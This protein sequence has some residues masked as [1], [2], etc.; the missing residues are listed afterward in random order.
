MS[1]TIVIAIGG[2]S[3][4]TDAQHVTVPAQYEAAF[5]T[6]RNLR[7]VRASDHRIAIV[8][9][10]GPQVSFI[11]RQAQLGA[12][13]LHMVPLDSCVADTQGA[14]DYN[15]QTAIRNVIGGLEQQRNVLTI[16][17]EVL[18]DEADPSFSDPSEPIGT[19]MSEK[20]AM[21]RRDRDGWAV[22]EDAGRGWRWVVPSPRP[23]EILELPVIRQLV[24]SGTI[25]IAAGGGG[26]PVIRT[27]DGSYAGVEAVIDKD[28]AA[29]LLARSLGA[30]R[31]VISTAVEKVYLNYGKPVQRAVE[32]M[33]VAAAR[34][35]TADGHFARGSMLPKIQTMIEFVEATG[36][37][38]IITD[39][40][41]L[42][43][44]LEG[45]SDTHIVP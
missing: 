35:Y 39:P 9:G 27:P 7:P 6:A 3:L 44:A 31:F 33:S 15:I 22:A 30:D 25:T 12:A 28:L 40:E 23:L 21:A 32:E 14:L 17:T 29:S 13:E 38:G 5:A 34:D 36:R 43:A 18:V 8:H 4:I 37:Q 16:V 11:L 1:E 45:E 2:N 24:E 26:I 42:A 10:N 20:E 19:F 41:H